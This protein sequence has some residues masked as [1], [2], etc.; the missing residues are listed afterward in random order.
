MVNPKDEPVL[1]VTLLGIGL[2]QLLQAGHALQFLLLFSFSESLTLYE[3]YGMRRRMRGQL[4]GQQVTTCVLALH[5]WLQVEDE[6]IEALKD[7]SQFFLAQGVHACDFDRP[8]LSV[9]AATHH[10]WLLRT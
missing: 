6:E 3:L 4:C 7:Q 2:G 1:P 9:M 8:A 5:Y 10:I